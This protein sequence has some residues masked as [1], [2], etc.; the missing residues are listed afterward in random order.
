MV[1]KHSKTQNKKE[2]EKESE[3]PKRLTIHMN[4]E[5]HSLILRAKEEFKHNTIA[6]LFDHLLK[7]ALVNP[8]K[9][10]I[11]GKPQSDLSKEIVELIESS[12]T[13]S[14]KLEEKVDRNTQLLELLVEKLI[15]EEE[16]QFFNFEEEDF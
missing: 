4:S 8:D 9:F 3:I 12:S 15:P 1:K 7:I 10:K 14:S 5:R 2:I 6:G 11:G 16:K 13:D